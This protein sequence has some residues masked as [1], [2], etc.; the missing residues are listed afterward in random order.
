MSGRWISQALLCGYDGSE[1]TNYRISEMEE[2]I[3][4]T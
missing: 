1:E 4:I 2:K 3:H